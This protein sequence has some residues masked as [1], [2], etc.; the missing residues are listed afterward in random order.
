MV[1]IE[2]ILD[3]IDYD[4]LVEAFLPQ[5]TEKLK[6]SGNPM[7]SMLSGSSANSMI[8]SFIGHMSESRKD[9]LAAELVN[10]NAETLKI[11][12]EN[13]ARSQG[14]SGKAVSLRATAE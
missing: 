14:I 4:A 8:K 12:L 5:I 11:Q 9:A 2:L 3:Q 7:A 13:Y 10:N 6:S 1:K